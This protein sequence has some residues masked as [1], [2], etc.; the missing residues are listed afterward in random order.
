MVQ[1]MVLEG[2]LKQNPDGS[3]VAVTDPVEAESIRS[4]YHESKRKNA[5]TAVD[6]EEINQAL[7]KLSDEDESEIIS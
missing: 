4:Q 6:A 5:M 2:H 7:D 3:M 1:G